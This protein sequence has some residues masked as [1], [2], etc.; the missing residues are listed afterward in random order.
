MRASR[1]AISFWVRRTKK[2]PK[3]IS[4]RSGAIVMAFIQHGAL[5]RGEIRLRREIVATEALEARTV[6]A[7]RERAHGSRHRG[8]WRVGGLVGA[9]IYSVVCWTLVYHGA[10]TVIAWTTPEPQ[11]EASAAPG[12]PGLDAGSADAASPPR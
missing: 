8:A 5:G 4:A 1:I 3:T 6:R 10:R 2:R 9:L 7:E 11:I 12:A